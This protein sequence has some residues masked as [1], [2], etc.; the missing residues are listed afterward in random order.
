MS[1]IAFF[2]EASSN[3]ASRNT[4]CPEKELNDDATETVRCMTSR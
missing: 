2:T 3:P 1:Q 4:I